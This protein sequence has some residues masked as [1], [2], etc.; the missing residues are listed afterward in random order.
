MRLLQLVR[1][2][3]DGLG[4]I[5]EQH[6]A[7]L[8]KVGLFHAL[9]LSPSGEK[10]AHESEEGESDER[11]TAHTHEVDPDVVAVRS[12]ADGLGVCSFARRVEGVQGVEVVLGQAGAVVV[13]R[14]PQHHRKVALR[15]SPRAVA[16]AGLRPVGKLE[17]GARN[18]GLQV[19]VA[20]GRVSRPPLRQACD[21][22]RCCLVGERCEPK[23][24]ADLMHREGL[25]G[26][27]VEARHEEP[28]VGDVGEDD[29]DADDPREPLTRQEIQQQ[30]VSGFLTF[31]FP[32]APKAKYA[33]S[34]HAYAKHVAHDVDAKHE[35]LHVEV[36]TR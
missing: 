25:E 17:Q 35:R 26:E 33:P 12:D 32:A 28:E 18:A 20:T 10:Q 27:A 21:A 4:L 7:V 34:E 13:R 8:H 19:A 36:V 31:A 22:P 24:D 29:E 3:K 9:L 2:V 11:D 15:A 14:G 1:P 23:R 16:A 30:L 5:T 6:Q